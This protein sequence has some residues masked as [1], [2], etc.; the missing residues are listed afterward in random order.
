MNLSMIRGAAAVLRRNGVP[1]TRRNVSSLLGLAR[2]F[3]R[4]GMGQYEALAY[5]AVF[6]FRPRP[7]QPK[8]SVVKR[9]G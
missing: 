7:V 5:A 3:T 9:A 4:D 1:V 2:S 6:V 8:G